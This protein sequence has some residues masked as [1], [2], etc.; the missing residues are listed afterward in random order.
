MVAELLHTNKLT[1]QFILEI[2]RA[3]GVVEIDETKIL[4]QSLKILSS[5]QEK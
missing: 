1:S 5:D 3:Q 4:K 2:L